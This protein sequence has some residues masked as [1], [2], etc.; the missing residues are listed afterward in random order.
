MQRT[1]GDAWS[2]LVETMRA[3]KASWPARG[4]SWDSRLNCVSSSF[5]TEFEAKARQ[6]ATSALPLEFVAASIARAPALLQE[7]AERAGGLRSGQLLL[8]AP[9]FNGALAYGLWWPWGDGETISFRVGLA[10]VD[11]SREP[12]PRFRDVFNVSL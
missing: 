3:L 12:Y 9:V 1:S 2:P 8:S 5:S 6:S 7:V 11:S 10:N 4:W